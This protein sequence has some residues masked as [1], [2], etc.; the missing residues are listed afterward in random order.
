MES[1]TLGN[2]C[3]LKDDDDAFLS[4]SIFYYLLTSTLKKNTNLN[5]KNEK[6]KEKTLHKTYTQ[7]KWINQT[8]TTGFLVIFPSLF[9]DLLQTKHFLSFSR[10]SSS[11]N[12]IY[13]TP[14][15]GQDMTQGQF[16][17]RVKQVSI[18][19]FPSPRL[20]ASPRPKNPACPTIYP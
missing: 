2:P 18:Q 13:P 6:L 16:L 5:L 15:L 4:I 19:S 8:L 7:Y 20:V 9:M 17:S 1:E 11:V 14:P 10:W 12:H 3:R